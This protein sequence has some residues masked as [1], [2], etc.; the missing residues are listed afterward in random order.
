MI[1]PEQMEILR[2]CSKDE[3]A[4]QKIHDVISS[5]QTDYQSELESKNNKLERARNELHKQINEVYEDELRRKEDELEAIFGATPDALAFLNADSRIIMV[6]PAFHDLFGYEPEHIIGRQISIFYADD[7]LIQEQRKFKFD[8]HGEIK[9]KRYEANYRHKGGAFIG[10]TLENTVK[11][12]KGKF[13]GYLVVI[14]DITLAKR[15]ENEIQESREQFRRL[16]E[17]TFEGIAIHAGGMIREI[18]QSLLLMTGYEKKE[19]TGNNV[20]RLIAAESRTRAHKFIL[21]GDENPGEITILRKNGSRFVSEIMCRNIPHRSNN[22]RVL[23]I[24]DITAHKEM[25]GRIRKSEEWLSTVIKSIGDAVIA[26]DE[27]GYVTFLNPVAESLSGWSH[28]EAV[29]APLEQVFRALDENTGEPLTNLTDAF[30]SGDRLGVAGNAILL[31]KAGAEIPV[32]SNATPLQDEFGRPTGIVLVFR[33]ISE[34]KK[35]EEELINAREAALAASQAKSEFLATMS[36]EIRTPLN[37]I[38][39]MSDLLWESRLTAEQKKFVSIFRTAGDNLLALINDILDLSKIEAGHLQA[40]EIHFDLR[41][42]VERTC[43]FIRIRTEEKNLA[44]YYDISP[45]TSAML[46]GDPNRLRQVLLNILG[47][48]VKFTHAGEVTLQIAEIGVEMRDEQRYCTLEFA[49]RD[50]GIGISEEKL[51]DVFDSFSQVDSSTT[52]KYGGTGLGLAISRKLAKLMGGSLQV[53]SKLGAGSTFTFTVELAVLTEAPPALS[54]GASESYEMLASGLRKETPIVS[55][56]ILL[57]ED[58][59][60]NRL[61]IQ[62]YLQRLPYR[63]DVAENGKEG[64]E[65]FKSG[66]YDLVLMDM[67]MPVMDGYSATA[68]IRRWES[69]RRVDMHNNLEAENLG[70]EGR[71]TPIIA[72]TAHAFNEDVKRSLGAGCTAHLTKPIKKDI[73][74]AA[75]AQYSQ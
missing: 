3:V 48:A 70:K 31:N 51:N 23:A 72:L 53:E 43:E 25:E 9:L 16:A 56:R 55:L 52:R 5:L 22:L 50:T 10:E 54:R 71:D 28:V 38:I 7:N 24:R 27:L 61:L 29:G 45:D 57:V 11:N 2:K 46:R 41:E 33:D 35:F 68:E 14:R 34:R 6:N 36:H 13:L 20:L 30:H 59:E 49:V 60:D 42:V 39:G 73:L 75:I 62:L 37:A 44:F 58:S 65:K 17:A 63:L 64:V 32:N 26:A 18:N 66:N 40:E 8:K 69:E 74:L 47:N 12:H 67:Q 15:A 19:L 21:E 1:S 4:L